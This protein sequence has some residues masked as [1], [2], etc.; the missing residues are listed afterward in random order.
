MSALNGGRA[1][2]LGEFIV[3]NGSTVRAAAKVFGISKSTVHKEVTKRLERQ[4]AAL[5]ARVRTV[6]DINRAQ[7]HLRGGEATRRKYEKQRE[8]RLYGAQ[9]SEG[10][11]EQH[12]NSSC[13]V[14]GTGVEYR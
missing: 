3:N 11:G 6:L 9:G 1:R 12:K 5:A 8:N 13:K 10:S 2:L 7:R 14:H 4:D